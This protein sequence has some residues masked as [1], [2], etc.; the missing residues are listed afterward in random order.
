MMK[1]HSIMS[2]IDIDLWMK[3]F[4]KIFLNLQNLSGLPHFVILITLPC[5][6]SIIVIVPLIRSFYLKFIL[7]QQVKAVDS[8]TYLG[9]IL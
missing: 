2:S 9:T 6:S 8:F 5:R 7:G 3:E 1:L 4:K